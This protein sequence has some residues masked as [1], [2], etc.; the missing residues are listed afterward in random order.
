MAEFSCTVCQYETANQRGYNIHLKS[1]KHINNILS[2]KKSVESDTRD[3]HNLDTVFHTNCL[4]SVE[5]VTM[6]QSTKCKYCQRV[7]ARKDSLLRHQRSCKLKAEFEHAENKR[8]KKEL[9]NAKQ[10]L[11]EKDIE[12]EKKVLEVKVEYL[13]REN[14]IREEVSK[15]AYKNTT[16]ILKY[17]TM[18]FKNAPNI[19]TYKVYLFED[20]IP[21]L[22]CNKIVD[23][24]LHH[25]NHGILAQYIADFI[26]KHYKT[27][28][29]SLQCFHNTDTV[30]KNFIFRQEN[31]L[32]DKKGLKIAENIIDPILYQIKSQLNIYVTINEQNVPKLS[33]NKMIALVRNMK[34]AADIIVTI[35]D[36]SLCRDV[37]TVLAPL[38]HLDLNNKLMLQDV[39]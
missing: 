34:S 39:V 5:I 2:N 21:K 33:T 11:K 1:R 36:N 38:F 35:D 20:N 27:D 14:K 12:L 29:I 22:E 32:C 18:H 16:N 24:I 3:S 15:T 30:R 26:T 8:I 13:E 31:W 23:E 4:Q 17:A 9:E 25:H 6:F 37:L 10:L 28:K 7:L 19:D